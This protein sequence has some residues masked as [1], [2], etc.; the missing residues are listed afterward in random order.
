M[1]AGEQSARASPLTWQ[2]RRRQAKPSKNQV[3][4]ARLA[5]ARK[6]IEDTDWCCSQLTIQQQ[7]RGH[8]SEKDCGSVRRIICI[9]LRYLSR[10]DYQLHLARVTTKRRGLSTACGLANNFGLDF[11]FALAGI[12]SSQLRLHAA[13]L[14]RFCLNSPKFARVRTS[15]LKFARKQSNSNCAKQKQPCDCSKQ[16]D[17]KQQADT[18]RAKA[19]A[20]TFSCS[21]HK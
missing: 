17:W 18:I 1:Q 10:R 13:R 21:R 14:Q 12:C 2:R 3:C 9:E 11:V 16:Q 4:C 5:T 6:P 7:N 15:S 20:W 8:Q 19:R